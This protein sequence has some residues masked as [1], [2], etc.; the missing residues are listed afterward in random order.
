MSR[1]LSLAVALALVLV[2]A[3]LVLGWGIGGYVLYEPDEARHAEVAR[4]M[5]SA[6]TWRDW[7]VPRLDGAPYLN[8]PA[9]FYWLMVGALTVFG[10]NEGAARTPSLVSALLTALATSLWGAR[11]WGSR[12]GALAG[13]ILVTAPEFA[14]LGRFATLDMTLTLW[15][16]LGMLAIYRF[17]ERFSERPDGSPRASLVPAALAG[18]LGMLAKGLLAPGFI[19]LVGI[20]WLA[21]RRRL[22]LLTPPTLA[23]AAVAFLILVLPWH[24]AAG[25]L[26]PGY[27]R[28]L[29]VDQ[30]WKRAVQAGERLHARPLLFYVPILLGGFFPWSALLPAAIRATIERRI[31]DTPARFCALWAAVVLVVLSVAQGKVPSYIVLAFPP[32]ALLTSHYLACVLWDEPS[33][34]RDE[35]FIRGGAWV[36]VAALAIAPVVVITVGYSFYEGVLARTSLW[37]LLFLVAAAA[38]ATLLRRGSLR[39][40]VT[41]LGAGSAVLLVAFFHLA[42]PALSEIHSDA[43]L[44][45]VIRAAP[46]HAAAPVVA[47]GLSSPSTGFYAERTLLLYDR[48]RQLRALL[49]D[50]ALVFVVTSPQHS[51][52]L[53]TIGQLVPWYVG[54]RRV[55]YASQP[56]GAG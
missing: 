29:Y 10:V 47:Y 44:G 13:L 25:T 50:H 52:E 35:R 1:H 24:L 26:D 7:I 43:A 42:A 40:V 45:R 36:V 15:T 34:S 2:I 30:Q 38:L 55:L 46:E 6:P 27:L 20:L 28:K 33:S 37:S 9:P 54:T 22:R 32:L 16:T 18:G 8:K 53:A 39:G 51:A 21:A 49:A 14:L 12:T 5:L 4:E 41:G 17:S 31:P 56:P 48:P 3:T 11:R 23:T 19:A